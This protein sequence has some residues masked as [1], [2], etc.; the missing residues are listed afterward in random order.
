[1][2]IDLIKRTKCH[3]FV[4]LEK[5]SS[6]GG[7]WHDNK[8]PGCCCDGIGLSG[9]RLF[10]ARQ[11][12]QYSMERVVQLLVRAELQLVSRVSRTGRDPCQYEPQRLRAM[13]TDMALIM[14][15]IPC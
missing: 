2:A 4:I 6:V 12:M 14:T 9:S 1:M 13:K 8:Y 10:R 5:S 11:L 7:T 15:G 3:N